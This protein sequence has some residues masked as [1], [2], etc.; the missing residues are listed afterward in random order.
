MKRLAIVLFALSWARP[1]LPGT[2]AVV[3]GH[4][5]PPRDSTEAL[6]PLRFA[7]D[8][9]ARFHDLFVRMGARAVLLSVLDERTQRRS[10]R[11][12]I[13]AREPSL[14]NLRLAMRSLREAMAIDRQRGEEVRFFLTYSGHG[15][16]SAS[17]EAF[18][19]L[20]DGALTEEVLFDEILRGAPATYLHLIVDA[21]NASGVVGA[22]GLFGRE[23]DATSVPVRGEDIAAA[24]RLEE[25]PTLGV[26]LA[27]TEGNASHEWSE[28]EAG[29]FT[30][31]VL[32]ALSGAADVNGDRLVEYSEVQAF[33]AAANRDLED[34]RAVP[35]VVA[36]PPRINRRAVL[37]ALDELDGTAFLRGAPRIGRFFIE[38]ENGQRQLDAH[39]S[40]DHEVTLALPA[41]GV[42]FLRAAPG[43]ALLRLRSGDSISFAR[44][45]F[46][47]PRTAIRGSIERSFHDELFASPF[48]VEYYRGF[49]DRTGG[50]PVD[51][52]PP[53]P[54]GRGRTWSRALYGTSGALLVTSGI[55]AYVAWQARRDFEAT[56]LQRSARRYADRY[57]AASAVAI[58]SAALAAVAAAGGWYFSPRMDAARGGGTPPAYS[59]V[60][61]GA[62]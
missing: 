61:T 53:V 12:A 30:H 10:P 48:T 56:T 40:G 35:D 52:V 7:D 29:V 34:P 49:V 62:W 13:A 28:V 6:D 44:L 11:A 45:A 24:S 41:E 54:P 26:L 2:Y 22:R 27:S 60:M 14:E 20:S 25:F 43:E 19:T 57:E 9:A 15:A 17:G 42:A 4:N 33:V 32:S 47:E 23:I 5:A 39:L 16:R 46:R 21:C 37:V 18:L 3:I 50:L 38:M 59:L 51:F 8:D 58:G 36:R 1:A 31:E 55:A